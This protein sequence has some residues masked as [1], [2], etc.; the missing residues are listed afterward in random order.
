MHKL[1]LET[2]R[3]NLRA[4]TNANYA[5]SRVQKRRERYIIIYIWKIT[6]H[7]VTN[8]DSTMWR[9][10]KKSELTQGMEHSVL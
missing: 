7:M 4:C 1:K 9:A 10:Q 8:I 5:S 6:Q 3:D 2:E